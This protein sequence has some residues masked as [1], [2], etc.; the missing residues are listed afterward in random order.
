M[1]LFIISSCVIGDFNKKLNN[2]QALI[3]FTAIDSL[4]SV[5]GLILFNLCKFRLQQARQA[6]E[7]MII[8]FAA[9]P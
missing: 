8:F 9:Y 1:V 5:G 2:F 4:T 7:W 3:Y 6:D